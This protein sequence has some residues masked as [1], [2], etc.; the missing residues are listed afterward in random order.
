MN[1]EGE[2]APNRMIQTEYIS[3]NN[4]WIRP[5]S[6][7]PSNARNLS[8]ITHRPDDCQILTFQDNNGR[9]IIIIGQFHIWFSHVPTESDE[10]GPIE[11]SPTLLVQRVID[12]NSPA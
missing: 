12:Q 2:Q 1:F 5:A 4:V 6:M 10:V 11:A 7:L 8:G 3:T 9:K